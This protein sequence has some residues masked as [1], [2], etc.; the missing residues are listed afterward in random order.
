MTRK[1]RKAHYY[2][3]LAI[4]DRW[5]HLFICFVRYIFRIGDVY[6]DFIFYP[7]NLNN[8]F[9]CLIVHLILNPCSNY[10]A[11]L[12]LIGGQPSFFYFI[13][14]NDWLISTHTFL[15]FI[16]S[17][18][19]ICSLIPRKHIMASYWTHLPSQEFD[20]NCVYSASLFLLNS[21]FF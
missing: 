1:R 17:I 20:N 21:F 5:S 10:H 12:L 11:L 4:N 16:S 19:F 18:A 7:I 8:L 2:A 3:C 14:S 13:R 6:F 9:C 15:L